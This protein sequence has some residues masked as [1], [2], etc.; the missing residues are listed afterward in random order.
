MDKM[1]KEKTPLDR[2]AEMSRAM[3]TVIEERRFTVDEMAEGANL[4]REYYPSLTGRVL[5]VWG[6]DLGQCSKCQ[7]ILP[8][9]DLHYE[10]GDDYLCETCGR[11]R[12]KNYG[13]KRGNQRRLGTVL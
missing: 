9:G 5:Y 4:V 8:H 7:E 1:T 2:L 11:W 10:E 13:E 6:Q 12:L 3:A